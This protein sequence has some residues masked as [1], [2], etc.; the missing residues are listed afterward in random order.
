M[1]REETSDSLWAA[2]PALALREGTKWDGVDFPGG[3]AGEGSGFVLAAAQV[4]AVRQVRLLEGNVH[5]LPKKKGTKE[6]Q[7]CQ[8]GRHEGERGRRGSGRACAQTRWPLQ[9]GCRLR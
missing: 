6:T 5:M 8:Q 1:K 4:A 7:E 2:S 9:L 3:T